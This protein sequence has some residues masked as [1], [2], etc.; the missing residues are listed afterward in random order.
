MA[1]QIYQLQIEKLPD[2][3][4]VVVDGYRR[5]S[6]DYRGPRFASTSID[7]ALK[8]IKE[9]LQPMSEGT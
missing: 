9:K 6:G 3:G 8:Y 2:G 5:D 4:Y 1:D 7:D